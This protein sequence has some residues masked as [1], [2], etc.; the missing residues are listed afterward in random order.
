VRVPGCQCVR[1][2]RPVGFSL[3]F[4]GKRKCREEKGLQHRDKRPGRW[5]LPMGLQPTLRRVHGLSHGDHDQQA[6]QPTLI[7][8]KPLLNAKTEQEHKQCLSCGDFTTA[9]HMS[10]VART[11]SQKKKKI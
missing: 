4:G 2:S 11:G 5:A 7:I 10:R 6:K 9:L 3:L 1:V 8:R